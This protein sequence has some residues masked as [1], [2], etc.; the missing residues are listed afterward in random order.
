[1]GGTSL[2][3]SFSNCSVFWYFASKIVLAVFRLGAVKGVD[4]FLPDFRVICAFLLNYGCAGSC[5][6][7]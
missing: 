1:M 5:T 4:L 7:G 2:H 6:P 3:Y